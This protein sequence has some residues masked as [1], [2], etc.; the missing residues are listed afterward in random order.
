MSK[1]YAII[2]LT[3]IAAVHLRVKQPSQRQTTINRGKCTRSPL[4]QSRLRTS[5]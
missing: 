3:G 5:M 1:K 4:S 2:A